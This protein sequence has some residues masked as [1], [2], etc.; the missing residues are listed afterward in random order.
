LSV[1]QSLEFIRYTQLVTEVFQ[2]LGV[3]RDQET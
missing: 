3:L 1:R 2:S